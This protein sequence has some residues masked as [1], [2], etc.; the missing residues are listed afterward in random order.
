MGAATEMVQPL[1]AG[2]RPLGPPISARA[3][4]GDSQRSASLPEGAVTTKA[5]GT[6]TEVASARSAVARKLP[7]ATSAEAR[8]NVQHVPFLVSKPDALAQFIR[9]LATPCLSEALRY[10]ILIE[11]R[12]RAHDATV[13][14]PALTALLSDLGQRQVNC[15]QS[16]QYID[17]WIKT[18]QPA[19]QATAARS[20]SVAI[21]APARMLHAEMTPPL[22]RMAVTRRTRHLSTH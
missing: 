15:A 9:E 3:L 18:L 11:I 12:Y 8:L 7:G 14:L 4:A 22:G 1:D 16:R 20:S 17:K 13:L 2:G 19:S 6:A 5:A 10:K 21:T